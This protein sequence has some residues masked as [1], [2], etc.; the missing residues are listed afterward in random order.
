NT[1]DFVP[2]DKRK[3]F[4]E[5]WNKGVDCILKCQ[6]KVDGKLT[7]WCAQHD[8]NDFSPRPA[9]TFELVSI[10]GCESVGVVHALMNVE[11]P[12]PEVVRAVDA[13]VAWLDAVKIPGVRIEDNPEL[14]Q[15]N[16]DYQHLIDNTAAECSCVVMC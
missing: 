14:D 8:E 16:R 12:S 9:R 1:Y 11:N 10:S 4:K 5:A 13:A 7:A 3:A 2:A 15:L 6:I